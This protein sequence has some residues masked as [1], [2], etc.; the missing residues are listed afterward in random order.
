MR[1]LLDFIYEFRVGQPEMAELGDCESLLTQLHRREVV[2]EG[3][4]AGRFLPIQE[5]QCAGGRTKCPLELRAGKS[6]RWAD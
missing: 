3:N 2:A 1:L 6:E 5:L 4:L